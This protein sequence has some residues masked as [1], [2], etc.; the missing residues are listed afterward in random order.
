MSNELNLQELFK[1]FQKRW[2]LI[3]IIT[4]LLSLAALVVSYR[5]PSTYEARMDLLVNYTIKNND[6]NTELQSSDIELS[7]RLIETYKQILQSDRMQG[8]VIA[9]LGEPHSKLELRDNI[10]IETDGNSQIITIVGREK[11]AEKAALLVNTYAVSFQ[12]EIKTLLNLDNIMIL[13]EISPVADV[14]ELKLSPILFAA[15]VFI[16]SLFILLFTLLIREFYFT[17]LNTAEKVETLLQIPNLGRIPTAKKE[18]WI[19]KKRPKGRRKMS[20]DEKLIPMSAVV[21]EEFRRIRANIQYQMA[22]KNTRT[23]MLTS[24]TFDESASLISGNLAIVMAMDGKRTIYVDANLRKP[25]GR[26][27]FN[28]PNRAG[29]TSYIAGDFE[30]DQIIQST[31]TDNLSFIS[32]GPIPSNPTEVLSSAKMRILIEK[33]K[34]QFDVIIIDAPPLAVADA[35]SLSTFVDGCLYVINPEQTKGE[36]ANKNLEHLR[37]VEAPLLGTILSGGH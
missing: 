36:L 25:I 18:K 3:A 8:N 4:V 27:I 26:Q 33:L 23:I 11:S 1:V 24:P 30:F 17:T 22:Q 10:S 29:L 19:T 7:L 35:I 16:S 6:E 2:K 20:K 32:S 28:L 37:K 15:M 13:D 14:K 9:K 31:A 21:I 5:L 34:A 12:E